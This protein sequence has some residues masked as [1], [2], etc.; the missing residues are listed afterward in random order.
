VQD[1]P[2]IQVE[3][4]NTG[5]LIGAEQPEKINELLSEFLG[6]E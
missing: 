2:D 4:L 6:E 5:H 3:V 1:I